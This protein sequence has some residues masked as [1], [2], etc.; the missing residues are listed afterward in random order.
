MQKYDYSHK[1]N[2]SKQKILKIV[3]FLHYFLSMHLL[4]PAPAI[5]VPCFWLNI[6]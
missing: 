1:N 6:F 3:T 4:L 5:F 2:E